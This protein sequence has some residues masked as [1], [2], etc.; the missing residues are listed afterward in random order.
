[1]IPIPIIDGIFQ[2]GSKLIEHFFPDPTK[3]AEAQLELIKLKETGRLADLAAETD[4][5]KGQLAINTEEAKSESVFVAGWRPAVGWIGA[6]GLGYAAIFEPLGRFLA[7]V[8]FG[9]TGDFPV[10][11]TN[12]TMQVLFGILGLGAMRSYDKLKGNGVEVGKN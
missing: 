3:A 12:I 10:I 8:V 6:L 4:L 7:S 9:Y 5:A 11:D 2:M 1:M